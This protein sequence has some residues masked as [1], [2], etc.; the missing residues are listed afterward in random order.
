MIT[1]SQAVGVLTGILF[2][3]SLFVAIY[4][5][6]SSLNIHHR[7]RVKF[8]R[9]GIG[10][11][12]T[13]ALLSIFILS[14]NAGRAIGQLLPVA[15]PMG[16]IIDGS[17]ARVLIFEG[18][19]SVV[20]R[21]MLIGYLIGLAIMSIQIISAYLKMRRLLLNSSSVSAMGQDVRSAPLAE[22]PFSFGFLNPQIF[23]PAHFLSEQSTD[24]LR[25]MLIHERTHVQ[26]HDPQWKLISL[27]TRA[28]FFFSPA[29]W[30]MHRKLDLETEIEC[31]RLTMRESGLEF[32]KYGNLLLDAVA[33]LQSSKQSPMFTYMSDSNLRGR[34]EAMKAKTIQRPSLSILFGSLVLI[35]SATAIA[36]TTGIS[37]V[38][39][40]YKVKA[41]ILVDGKV[42]STPQF[43][44]L[45]NEPASLEMKAEHPEAALRMML[46]ASDYSSADIA[47]GIDLKMAVDYKTHDRSFRANPRV[48]VAPGEEGVVTIGSG[49]NNTMEMKI[50]AERQ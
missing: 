33:V 9:L 21:A 10:A 34:I 2:L 44:V 43:I 12:W 22:S 1:S 5:L 6:Q 32:Q 36:A 45:P 31:D 20:V 15:G 49:A 48:V 18:D 39:G 13:V 29:S 47:N 19:S 25:V 26:N 27:L 14:L 8:L 37:K 30:Y 4:R 42:V 46:T 7:Q 35:A 17:K 23:L 28:V 3:S 24:A 38:K 16:K 50:T 40:Q 11:T 41:E